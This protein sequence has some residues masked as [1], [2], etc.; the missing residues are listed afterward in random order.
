MHFSAN[1]FNPSGRGN[2]YYIIAPEYTRYSAGARVLYSLC[3]ALNRL[4]ESAY[5]HAPSLVT[6]LSAPLLSQS[7]VDNHFGSG[8][9]PITV[10]PEGVNGNPN[11]AEFCVRYLL[12]FPGALGGPVRFPP[13]DYILCFT[14]EIRDNYDKSSSLLCIPTSDVNTFNRDGEANPRKGF[15]YYL[16]KRLA[17]GKPLKNPPQPDWVQIPWTNRAQAKELSREDLASLLRSSRRLYLYENTSLGLDA[18]LCG[19]PVV[20]MVDDFETEVMTLEQ[21]K[22]DG[23]AFGDSD[24]EITRAESTVSNAY[25]NYCDWSQA[26]GE[27]L[28]L[29]ISDTQ[30]RV[31]RIRYLKKFK[32]EVRN[33]AKPR[34]RIETLA[35]LFRKRFPRLSDD[36][37]AGF[38]A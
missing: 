19:C 36:I 7:I 12:N 21:M 5:M 25:K 16:K 18:I 24:H 33:S 35:R 28:E 27:E 1:F 31:S 6:D 4:G 26:A 30:E 14:K 3:H 29:F 37:R 23:F 38:N 32:Y 20:L 22:T 8:R 9:T 15:C 2:P 17:S 13:N 10:Y 11:D 34:G